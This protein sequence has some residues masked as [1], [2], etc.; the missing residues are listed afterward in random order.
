MLVLLQLTRS[1]EDDAPQEA[2]PQSEV[3]RQVYD[4][5]TAFSEEN[6]DFHDFPVFG[7]PNLNE[8]Q[9]YIFDQ[10]VECYPAP[11]RFD[12][13]RNMK[14]VDP[15]YGVNVIEREIE[16]ITQQELTTRER[17]VGMIQTYFTALSDYW[18]QSRHL[19]L[20]LSLER[21][22]QERVRRGLVSLP[23]QVQFMEKVVSARSAFSTTE[24]GLSASVVAVLSVC[25]EN[26]RGK[27]RDILTQLTVTQYAIYSCPPINPIT[28]R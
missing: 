21:R 17:F 11:S 1:T 19:S 16:R 15:V 20:L 12:S 8:W 14:A 2:Q 4:L 18:I 10:M 3:V 25:K 13:K 28:Q 9:E 6:Y 7:N 24:V 22:S 26:Q 23:E 5:P 27:L